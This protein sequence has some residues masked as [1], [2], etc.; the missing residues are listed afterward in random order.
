MLRCKYINVTHNIYYIMADGKPFNA[1]SVFE[2]MVYVQE[3]AC[4]GSPDTAPY[5]MEKD[6]LSPINNLE[7]YLYY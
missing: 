2:N 4:V 3:V 5:L 7:L 1:H 6:Y